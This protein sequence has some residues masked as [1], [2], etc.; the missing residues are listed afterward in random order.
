[1]VVELIGGP[2]DGLRTE[3]GCIHKDYLVVRSHREGPVYSFR[4]SKRKWH[5]P[6]IVP[7]F[8]LCYEE[9]AMQV[10]HA[11]DLQDAEIRLLA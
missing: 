10:G 1:M 6:S 9:Q 11:D 4:G 7:C 5:E 8:F 2:L 3:V